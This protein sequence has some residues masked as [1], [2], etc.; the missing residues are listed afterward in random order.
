MR[1]TT[2]SKIAILIW[3]IWLATLE[4]KKM[5]PSLLGSSGVQWSSAVLV[6]ILIPIGTLIALG[7]LTNPHTRRAGLWLLIACVTPLLINLATAGVVGPIMAQSNAK[8]ISL[9][10]QDAKMIAKFTRQ[11]VDSD[12]G[13]FSMLE[14]KS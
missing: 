11:A 6:A 10:M 2:G 1:K 4:G 12:V 9:H 13:G 3:V 7:R 5:A 14:N 8:L